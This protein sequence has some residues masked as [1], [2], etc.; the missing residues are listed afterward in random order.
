[1][2]SQALTLTLAAPESLS[3]GSVRIHQMRHQDLAQG[4]SAKQAMISLIHF[5]GNHPLVGYHIRYDKSIFGPLF[6]SISWL[7][8]AQP[9]D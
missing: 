6:S 2:T 5:I 8:T 3:A 7:S 1:M 4:V 9:S